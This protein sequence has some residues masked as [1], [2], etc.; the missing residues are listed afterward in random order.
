MLHI[1]CPPSCPT[2]KPHST[3]VIVPCTIRCNDIDQMGWLAIPFQHNV[4]S[5]SNYAYQRCIKPIS[6]HDNMRVSRLR[7]LRWY[8]VQN[9]SI[10]FSGAMF[11]QWLIYFGLHNILQWQISEWHYM[12]SSL[13]D[14]ITSMEVP[15]HHGNTKPSLE[16]LT[17]A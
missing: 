17:L 4:H 8:L 10:S 11:V 5:V 6:T 15:W 12:V 7:D 9:F 14:S 13:N 1:W 3:L 16:R 2:H